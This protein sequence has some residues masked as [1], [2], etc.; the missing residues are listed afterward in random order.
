MTW[1]LLRP[2]WLFMLFPIAGLAWVLWRKRLVS[3]DWESVIDS[4]LLHHLLVGKRGRRS[5]WPFVFWLI[6][7]ILVVI[8][9]SGP[10]RKKIS[11]PVFKQQSA[12]VIALDLSRSMNATDIKPSRLVRAR[13]KI[14]DLLKLRNEGQTALLAYAATAYTVSPLTDDTQTI[15]SL[16][17][18]LTTEIM[19]SQ[20]SRADLAVNKAVELL[21]NSGISKG[22]I[23]LITDGINDKSVNKIHQMDIKNFRISVLAVG[24]EEGA[25]IPSRAGGFVKDDKGSIV[26]AKTDPVALGSIAASLGGIYSALTIDDTDL[27]SLRALSERFQIA[28]DHE[29]TDFKADRWQE[30]GPWLLLL[31]TPLAALAFRR[32][33]FPGLLLVVLLL[34]LPERVFAADA[35]WDNLWKNQDQRA[36]QVFNEGD[37]ENAARLFKNPDWK[38]AAHYQAGQYEQALQQL[39]TLESDEVFYNRGNTLAKIGKL[40]EALESYDQLLKK[41]P[42]HE[43][44]IYNRQ[45]V[46]EALKQQQQQQQQQSD[47]AEQNEDQ[48]QG[49]DASDQQQNNQQPDDQ[50]TAEN[51]RESGPQDPLADQKDPQENSQTR[52]QEAQ[53]QENENQPSEPQQQ[54]KTTADKPDTMEQQPAEQD[55]EENLSKQAEAQW[56]RRIPDDPGGLLRNKFK[57]QY[58]QQPQPTAEQEQW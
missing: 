28:S 40:E 34:P 29:Q 48:Q 58:G 39:D 6:L 3:R 5:A 44:G 7:S 41:Q 51:Q 32:G 26:I 36:A 56:L 21:N 16:I 30:E 46:E 57:Y 10:V 13:L 52:E 45:L 23:L 33:L 53:Q 25:P 12:L 38:A 42:Q 22:D 50:S 49:S 11:V 43:D 18:S 17:S 37:T 35:W 54:N 4:R 15:E 31:V 55:I 24:T 8:A 47:S 27:Q 19:P 9:L 2:E 20:G 1:Q 14:I